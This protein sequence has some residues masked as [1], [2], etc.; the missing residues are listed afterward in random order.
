MSVSTQHSDRA[1]RLE[2]VATLVRNAFW[3]LALGVVCC[4]AFF[5]AL[6]AVHPG[7]VAGLTVAMGVLAALWI[8]HA[9]LRRR[10]DDHRDPALIRQRE[11]R[12]F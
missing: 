8:A 3:V 11:R 1:E 12:G 5:V 2:A 4:F 10:A 9:Y 6:G 7:Q